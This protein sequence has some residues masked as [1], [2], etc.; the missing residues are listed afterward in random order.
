MVYMAKRYGA[1][2]LYGAGYAKSDFTTCLPAYK[3]VGARLAGLNKLFFGDLI[4][5]ESVYSAV[6]HRPQ[7]RPGSP[8]QAQK[9][10]DGFTYSIVQEALTLMHEEFSRLL[11]S[12]VYHV[13]VSSWA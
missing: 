11:P 7:N 4:L 5:G 13:L 9:R 2:S 3:G 6:L 12:D 10:H 1:P 8:K